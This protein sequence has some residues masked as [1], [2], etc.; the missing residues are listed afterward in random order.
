MFPLITWDVWTAL[1]VV[2]GCLG[3]V[4]EGKA[5]MT[6]EVLHVLPT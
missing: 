3:H 4:V 6:Y 2:A 1:T 5:K